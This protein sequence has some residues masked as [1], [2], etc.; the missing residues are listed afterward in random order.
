MS[1]PKGPF[2]SVFFCLQPLTR[3][4]CSLLGMGKYTVGRGVAVKAELDQAM[5]WAGLSSGPGSLSSNRATAGRPLTSFPGKQQSLFTWPRPPVRQKFLF[6]GKRGHSCQLGHQSTMF[7][8]LS[9]SPREREAPV[10]CLSEATW[11][12]I[13]QPL[14]LSHHLSPPDLGGLGQLPPENSPVL[15]KACRTLGGRYLLPP[16][17]FCCGPTCT[18]HY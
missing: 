12:V 2:E 14:Q 8:K 18:D 3:S 4:P 13:C 15:Q 9:A 17:P 5:E 11:S 10:P 6:S 7:A 16:A 1:S